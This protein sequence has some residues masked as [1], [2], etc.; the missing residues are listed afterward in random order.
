MFEHLESLYKDD[1][2][3]QLYFEKEDSLPK[4]LPGHIELMMSQ[5]LQQEQL[6]SQNETL[7]PRRKRSI[8][9]VTAAVQHLEQL[10]QLQHEDGGHR[11]WSSIP[12]QE[13]SEAAGRQG[14]AEVGDATDNGGWMQCLITRD[15]NF[16]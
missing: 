10:Q 2:A 14:L 1:R 15:R 8:K 3:S 12:D 9:T 16:R 7:G 11:S 6:H 13:G 5:L 4:T